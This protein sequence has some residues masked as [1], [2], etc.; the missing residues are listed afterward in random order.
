MPPTKENKKNDDSYMKKLYPHLKL[1]FEKA[2]EWL[3]EHLESDIFKE[4]EDAQNTISSIPILQEIVKNN[5]ITEN[6]QEGI[7]LKGYN[8]HSK[9]FYVIK[10][11]AYLSGF[12]K[13]DAALKLI[14]YLNRYTDK[15]AFITM[16]VP[17][18]V[19]GDLRD[20]GA[21]ITVTVQASAK[22]AE[23]ATNFTTFSIAP[24]YVDPRGFAIQKSA[25][26]IR[27]DVK[28]Q[29]VMCFDPQYG[30]LAS[31]KDGL[32]ADVLKGLKFN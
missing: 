24:Q 19:E 15:V 17:T 26:N 32:Y 8:E 30:R 9:K 23:K 13:H 11:R 12:M 18:E 21:N 3:I 4:R 1:S 28:V 22:T 7:I 27:E 5:M 16:V 14:N 20:I 10:E 31:S 29:L 6:S 25:S 2:K